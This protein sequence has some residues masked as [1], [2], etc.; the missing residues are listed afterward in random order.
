MN[1]HEKHDSLTINEIFIHSSNIGISKIT[2]EIENEN[3]YR[4]CKNLGFGSVT[5]IP[6]KSES[7][8]ILRNIK[9]WSKCSK[10]YISIGQEI[11]VTNIQLALAYSS[12]AN[13][14]YLLK[15]HII[16]NIS[17]EDSIIYH[18]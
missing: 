16:K 8:G 17:I 11:G 10:T 2:Q 3:I 12:I 1:D 4:I 15:P 9:N 7:K 18:K 14:G 6:L 13:G 5:G